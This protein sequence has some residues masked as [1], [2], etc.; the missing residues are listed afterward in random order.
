MRFHATISPTSGFP[1]SISGSASTGDEMRAL[2]A[3]SDACCG[4]IGF[5]I[6][7]IEA[8]VFACVFIRNL[9]S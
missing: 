3:M 4:L 8:I 2:D 6:Q 7:G 5:S 1:S 9:F